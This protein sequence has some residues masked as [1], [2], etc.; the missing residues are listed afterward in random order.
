[1][2]IVLSSLSL[3]FSFLSHSEFFP[4]VSLKIQSN[5]CEAVGELTELGSESGQ[6][7]F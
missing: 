4:P 1:M 3:S 7:V 5:V 2:D 6:N